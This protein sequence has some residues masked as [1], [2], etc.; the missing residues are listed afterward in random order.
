MNTHNYTSII[1]LS[2]KQEDR[3]K[4][5]LI[6]NEVNPK[7]FESVHDPYYRNKGG[8]NEVYEIINL[9]YNNIVNKL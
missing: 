3:D 1:S 7:S 6:L 5:D 8:F 2:R 4:V 9:A